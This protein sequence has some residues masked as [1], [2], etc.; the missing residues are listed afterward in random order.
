M[1]EPE[2]LDCLGRIFLSPPSS[3]F[4]TDHR[5][6]SG[7]AVKSSVVLGLCSSSSSR[8][9]VSDIGKSELLQQLL[10]LLFSSASRMS[11][12]NF[13]GEAPI[14]NSCLS[15]SKHSLQHVKPKRSRGKEGRSLT[16]SPLD[17]LVLESH[18]HYINE[19]F[20][21]S[22]IGKCRERERRLV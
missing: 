14:I 20:F 12:L 22:S 15:P 6:E 5:D 8:L 17:I 2:T 9:I 7:E 1:D 21:L 4:F 10:S 19:L 3:T 13:S 16:H 11:I 18:Y